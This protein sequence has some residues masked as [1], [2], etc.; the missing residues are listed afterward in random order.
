MNKYYIWNKGHFEGN[1]V[2]FW[3]QNKCGYT[4]NLVEAGLWDKDEAFDICKTRPAEDVPL[5]E[6]LVRSCS[7]VVCNFE[8]LKKVIGRKKSA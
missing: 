7:Q 3:K 6:H 2:I 8:R 1:C 5:K 4:V